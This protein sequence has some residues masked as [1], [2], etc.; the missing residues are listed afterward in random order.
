LSSTHLVCPTNILA[1]TEPA[2]CSAEVPCF[3]PQASDICSP[4]SLFC[5]PPS[6][7][8]FPK[9]TTGV[10]CTAAD[11][12]GNQAT[13]SFTVTVEDREAPAIQ[14]LVATPGVLTPPNHQMVP[15]VLRV[16]ATDNCGPVPSS[17]KDVTSSDPVSGRVRG[18]K[19]PDYEIT[20]LLTLNLRAEL[21]NRAL[22]RTYRI[23]VGCRD[24]SGNAATRSVNVLVTARKW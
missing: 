18:D 13:C 2:R 9:G 3:V 20:G 21:S 5:Q 23:T 12:S 8:A 15:V 6:G 24:T 16:R 10:T 14:S 22:S 1:A 4:I 17:I 7:S 11:D 19:S